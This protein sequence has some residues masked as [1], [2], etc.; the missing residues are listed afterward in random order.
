MNVATFLPSCESCCRVTPFVRR[1]SIRIRQGAEAIAA[2][3]CRQSS[4]AEHEE[5]DAAQRVD[6]SQ[7]EE[8]AGRRYV[9]GR[10]AVKSTAFTP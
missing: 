4:R 9:A 10:V 7:D 2:R 3:A 5:H 6:S 1:L 8:Q